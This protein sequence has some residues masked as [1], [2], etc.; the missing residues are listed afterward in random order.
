MPDLKFRIDAP[1]RSIDA[2][3]RLPD[4]PLQPFELIPI[5]YGLTDAVVS[6]SESRTVENGKSISCRAGCGACCRQLVP[7]SEPEAL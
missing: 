5:L 1:D 2:S 4:E 6:M 7:V 3:A